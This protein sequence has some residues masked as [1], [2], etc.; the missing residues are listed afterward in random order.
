MFRGTRAIA[1]VGGLLKVT[2][3]IPDGFQ[4]GS[5]Q[6]PR[7][8]GPPPVTYQSQKVARVLTNELPLSRLYRR[9]HPGDLSQSAVPDSLSTTAPSQHSP[10]T[11]NFFF[12]AGVSRL[13]HVLQQNEGRI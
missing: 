1:G 6:M 9:W 3:Y 5:L 13:W 4:Q 7:V 11:A 10:Y 12:L 8:T 2:C